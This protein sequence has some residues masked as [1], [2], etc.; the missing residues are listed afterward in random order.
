MFGR[1]KNVCVLGCGPAGLFAA[2]AFAEAGWDVT[3]LSKKRRSEM[4]GAQYLHKPIPGLTLDPPRKIE[5]QLRGTV[6]QYAEKVY[7]GKIP[8]DRVSP[9]HFAGQA[10]AWDIRASYFVAWAKYR[11]IIRSVKIEASIIHD[12]KRQ[13]RYVLCTI[14]AP[15]L[16]ADMENK[17]LFHSQRVWA[18]GDAPE[19]GIEAPRIAPADTVICN[20]EPEPSWYRASNVFGYHTVEWAHDKKPPV[21]NVAEIHK[22]ISTNCDCH[23]EGANFYRVGRYGAWTKGILSHFGYELAKEMAK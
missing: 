6:E 7:E 16:C 12:L 17:H 8:A 14:P 9:A 21:S 5:Y 19:R 22:P 4:F 15:D 2:H 11:D 3:I 10:E 1:K 13:F 23:R 20:G 18:V